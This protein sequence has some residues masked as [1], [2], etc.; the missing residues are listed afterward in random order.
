MLAL[1][2]VIL[3]PLVGFLVLLALG[4]KIGNP[5]AGYL[6]TGMI[7]AAFIAAIVSWIQLL[8][9]PSSDRVITSHLFTWF[10]AGHLHLSI[11]FRLDPLSTVM[12]LFV[13]GVAAL[14]HLYSIGYMKEDPRYHQFFVYLNLFVF[15][16]LVLVTAGNLALTFLGWEGVGACSYWLISFWF[17]RPAAATAGKKAFIVNR[18]G[19]IGF[20]AG[21]FL[22]F[23]HLG[24]LSYSSFLPH[25]HL[26][27]SGTAEAIALCFFVAAV[28]KSAQIPLFVWLLDAMEGPTPV[29]ALIH[30]ATMVTAGVYLMARIS[31]ILALAP[32]AQLVIA[33]LGVAT[34][35]IAAMAA[36]SQQDIKKIVAY[37]TVSQLGFMML[38]IGTGA[39]VAA[40]FLMVTHAFYKALI[41]LS[42]GS[43]IHSLDSEQDIRK[44]GALRKLMPITAITMILAWLSIAG[45]PP[46]S[47]FFSK[48]SVIENAYG[49]SPYL[50]IFAVLAAILTA[51]YMGRLVYR[52]FYEEPRWQEVT[53]G[54][55]PHESGRVM[56][57]PLIVLATASVIA[58][59]LDLPIHGLEYLTN[60]LGPVF[61]TALAHYHLSEA[62]KLSLMGV[63]A[64]AALIGIFFAW[65]IWAKSGTHP[66]LEPKV[67]ANGWY[68]DRTYDRI[69]AQPGTAMANFA[70][71]T[72]D[73]V[74][75]DGAVSGVARI[76]SWIGGFG[77]SVQSGLVRS[78]LLIVVAGV[79]VM[80]GYVLVAATR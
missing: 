72:V 2:L 38:G 65:R 52:V 70:D 57:I 22:V 37:S 42:S 59:L 80:L 3:F 32:T 53:N 1:D 60:W 14:I 77:K 9:R 46:F 18:V 67:L 12:I 55:A 79:V 78:Y 35:F 24:S 40:I 64:V 66:A 28:G 10:Q 58:G 20:L 75:I 68:V 26:L 5:R 54:H 51:Y 43:V 21:S 19:D 23:E 74:V 27:S 69:F 34:A 15:T 6:A 56:T 30:A 8:G 4:K 76:A 63:D 11:A 39:Y 29:S 41:F 61:G 49:K 7:L 17:D 62:T 73:P 71:T 48:G 44:M 16:M 47:G 31:P 33:I 45:V 50:W 25:A 13:T 36:T